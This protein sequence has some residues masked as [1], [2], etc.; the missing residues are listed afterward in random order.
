[1]MFRNRP[2]PKTVVASPPVKLAQAL[3]GSVGGPKNVGGL[4]PSDRPSYRSQN[5]LSHF[6]DFETVAKKELADAGLGSGIG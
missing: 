1:M 4:I 5:Y 3:H 6:H 2:N